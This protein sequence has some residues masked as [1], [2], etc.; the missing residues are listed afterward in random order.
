MIITLNEA[1]KHLNIGLDFIEDDGYIT[2]LIDVAENLIEKDIRKSIVSIVLLE[3]K[4]PPVLLHAA[5]LLIG[6]FYENREDVIVGASVNKIPLSYRYLISK[7]KS[8]TI[9]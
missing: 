4:T 7:Y 1:K 9:H 3:G 2:L 6:N 5:K 8:Y